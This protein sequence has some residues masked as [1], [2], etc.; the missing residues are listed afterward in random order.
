[1]D[2]LEVVTELRLRRETA[3]NPKLRL[4]KDVVAKLQLCCAQ[5]TSLNERRLL[6]WELRQYVLCELHAD[7]LCAHFQVS[8]I[9]EL[10][11]GHGDEAA[12]NWTWATKAERKGRSAPTPATQKGREGG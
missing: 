3:E 1:M 2:K 9:G 10:G 6:G 7:A 4:R 8:S 12:C 11:L 5:P